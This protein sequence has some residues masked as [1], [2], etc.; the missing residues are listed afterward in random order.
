MI[1]K[2]DRWNVKCT[3]VES[4]K[5][6]QFATECRQIRRELNLSINEMAQRMGVSEDMVLRIESGCVSP[7]TPGLI[8]RINQVK[9]QKRMIIA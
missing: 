7:E 8:R 6:K 3:D 4:D 5:R 9:N 2:L 1:S